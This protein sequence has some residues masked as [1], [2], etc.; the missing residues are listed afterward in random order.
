M[1]ASSLL[2]L[3]LTSSA[4]SAATYK[5]VAQDGSTSYTDTPCG[6]D[7]KSQPT[8]SASPAPAVPLRPTTASPSP[9]TI[10]DE[11]NRFALEKTAVLCSTQKFNAWVGSHSN[12]LPDPDVRRAKFIEITNQCRR[13]VGL[14]DIVD[15]APRIQ[16]APILSGPAGAAAAATLSELVKS[17]SIERLQKYLSSPGVDINDRPGNDEAL[18]D[19]A[20]EQNAVKVAR[21]LAEHGARVNAK[22]TQGPTSGLT[23]LH[24]AAT[25][26]AAEVAE[27]LLT[28]AAV[29]APHGA[30]VNVLGPLG[31]TPLILAASNGSRR[32]AEVLLNHGANISVPTG[33]LKTA[34]SEAE[35][36]GHADIVK[37]LLIHVP[38]PDAANMNAVAARGDLEGLRLMLMHDELMHDVAKSTK[39]RALRYVIVGGTN[40]VEERTQMIELLLSHGADV[41]NQVDNA[42]NT[43]V[44]LSKTPA[45]LAFLI[46]RGA[47]LKAVM[48]YGTLAQAIACDRLVADPVGLFKVLYAH[49]VD[50][51]SGMQC[52][53]S[54][55]R[56]ELETYLLAQGVPAEIKA[57]QNALPPANSPATSP[58]STSASAGPALPSSQRASPADVTALATTVRKMGGDAEDMKFDTFAALQM[59]LFIGPNDPAWNHSNPRYVALFKIVRQDLQHDL[60]P[61]LQAQMAQGIRELADV[62]G[63]RIPEADVKQLLGFYRSNKGQRYIAFQYR[64]SAVQAQGITELTMGLAGA[65]MNSA[66]NPAPSQALLDQ[67]RRLMTDSWFSLVLPDAINSFKGSTSGAQQPDAGSFLRAMLDVVARNH[68]PEIDVVGREYANDLPQFESFHRSS[69]A[70]SLLAAMHAGMEMAAGRPVSSDPFKV[71]LDRSIAMHSPQW[72]AAY[73]AGRSSTGNTE[74][75]DAQGDLSPLVAL[76]QLAAALEAQKPRVLKPGDADYPEEAAKPARVIPLVVTGHDGADMRFNTEWVSDEKLCG[77]QVGLGG[78]FA[79]TLSFPI[80]MTRSGDT[81]RGSVVVDGFK[82]GKCA[83]RFTSVGYGMIDGVQNALAMPADHGDPPVPQRE[84]WCY[85]VTYEKKSLHACEMLAFLRWSNAMRA[86][87]PDFLSQFSHQQQSDAHVLGITSQTKE[88]HVAL[89]DLNTIPGALIPVGDR[90]AQLARAKAD[91]AAREQT[92]EYKAYKCEDEE[93]LDWIKSHNKPL[94]DDATQ[95]AAYEAIHAKCRA[96]FGLPPSPLG[97]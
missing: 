43:P 78:Y 76:G 68:G 39:D 65:G 10:T 86:V 47:D 3:I 27:L 28:H 90:E 22:Q 6:P 41:N 9:D 75:K 74:S 72:K 70:K 77:H 62:L 30:E 17:G 19:Y 49:G 71:A 69:A 82:P 13:S 57:T 79:Y 89:H 92:P 36:H 73:E 63:S 11:K 26:D 83:W 93:K 12:P 61:A 33:H 40:L 24:R 88:I 37:L 8:A 4:S 16:A 66:S 21:F 56:Q 46:A 42:P 18:L 34:L 81:Y 32:T 80:A 53:V 94:P 15:T 35:A 85:R 38:V 45:M 95:R 54:L 50:A 96:E 60:E 97:S 5:C 2:A 58:T 55:H 52:A 25:A 84:F 7:L 31:V 51:A 44:M 87:N 29:D 1:C 20:A 91:Q 64:L 14:P 67:R 48:P 23:A 59:R